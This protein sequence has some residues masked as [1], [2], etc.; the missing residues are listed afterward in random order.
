MG[1][2]Y[3]QI[4]VSNNC[5]YIEHFKNEVAI[6]YLMLTQ[7]GGL[8]NDWILIYLRWGCGVICEWRCCGGADFMYDLINVSKGKVSI[9]ISD[10]AWMES[11]TL[12]IL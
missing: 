4:D 10:R 12:Y 5:P 9:Y 7:M 3:A 11:L 6:L 8:K 2:G 1:K